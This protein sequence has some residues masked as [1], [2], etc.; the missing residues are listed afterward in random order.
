MAATDQQ[1][2]EICNRIAVWWKWADVA[3]GQA[4]ANTLWLAWLAGYT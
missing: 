4:Y 1:A 3:R 2:T